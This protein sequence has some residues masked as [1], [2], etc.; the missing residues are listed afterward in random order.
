MARRSLLLAASLALGAGEAAAGA[1]T[2]AEGEIFASQT[3]RYF[4]TEFSASRDVDFAK[5]ALGF[6][7][8]Y[9][10]IDGLTLG[11]EGDQGLRLDDAGFGAQDGR[12]RGFARLRLGQ[13]PWGVAALEA[14]GSIAL[15]GF[16]SPAVPGGDDSREARVAL[17]YGLGFATGLGPG[18]LDGSLAFAKFIGPRADEVKLDLTLGLRPDEN[19]VATA[20]V[21]VT[22][23]LRNAAFGGA[24]FD[25]AKAQLSVGRRLDARRTLLLGVARD[26]ATRGTSGGYELSLTLWSAF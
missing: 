1:W 3:L 5:A 25:L 23:G 10:L 13:G 4:S 17:Q 8:E 12:A 19:W 26:V 6:Y 2:R 18:W 14:G 7:A 22:R 20:Q 15:N 16:T 11:V 24:D 9:G 21:F